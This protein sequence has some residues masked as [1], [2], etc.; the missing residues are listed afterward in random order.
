M[1]HVESQ[2]K[3]K[4]LLVMTGSATEK[5]YLDNFGHSGDVY[6]LQSTSYSLFNSR[7]RSH[8]Y[9]ESF[10]V[11]KIGTEKRLLFNLSATRFSDIFVADSC[12]DDAM[13][14]TDVLNGS[15]DLST[16][17]ANVTR[18]SLSLYSTRDRLH[19]YVRKYF[20][21]VNFWF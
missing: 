11:T 7:L 9:T 17:M 19:H 20:Y 13:I 2:I 10:H 4:A 3:R 12:L 14:M 8:A 18:H 1:K 16:S 21:I 6:E 5:S 15:E